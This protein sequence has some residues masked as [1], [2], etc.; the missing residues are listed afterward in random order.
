M[1]YDFFIIV[2]SISSVE[3]KAMKLELTPPRD[4]NQKRRGSFR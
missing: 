2:F 4:R 1:Y 3:G